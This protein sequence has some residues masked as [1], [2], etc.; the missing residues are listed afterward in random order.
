VYRGPGRQQFEIAKG[1]VDVQAL[2]QED[3]AYRYESGWNVNA[4]VATG[5]GAIFSS[6][7][8][9]FTTLM[10]SWWGIYGWFIGV[11]IGGLVY[12]V[13]AS[14]RPRQVKAG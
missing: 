11:L 12:R 7:L 14:L 6:I 8:P 13:M 1:E 9:N 5:V 4:L 10:P 3:G 2:Y